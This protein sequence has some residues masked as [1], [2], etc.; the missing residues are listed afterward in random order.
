M[1]IHKLAA[2]LGSLAFVAGCAN[3]HS[4]DKRNADPVFQK[5]GAVA[6]SVDLSA[7]SSLD[8]CDQN[9]AVS[10]LDRQIEPTASH[11]SQ[12]WECCQYLYACSPITQGFLKNA[13]QADA[14]IRIGYADLKKLKVPQ[15]G[16]KI[17][18]MYLPKTRSV[19]L[20]VNLKT[21]RQACVM[22]LHEVVHAFDPI[23]HEGEESLRTEFR[24]YWYQTA[25]TDELLKTAGPLG[26]DA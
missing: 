26:D 18:G 25:L 20:D 5:L 19:F 3:D 11:A 24:A 21:P 12:M 22:L 13:F 6:L 16:D 9:T 10:L 2:L 23:A 8:T 4:K 14:T 1:Q 7:T 17:G 15:I